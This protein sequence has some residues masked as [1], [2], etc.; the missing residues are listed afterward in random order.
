MIRELIVIARPEVGIRV[1]KVG[2]A[3]A[4]GADVTPLADFLSMEDINIQPL[5]GISEEKLKQEASSFVSATA[6]ELSDLSV[7]Y[8]VQAPD[9]RLDMISEKYHWSTVDE[10]GKDSLWSTFL[11]SLQ[12]LGHISAGLELGEGGVERVPGHNGL[13]GISGWANCYRKNRGQT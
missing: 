13:V 6:V 1:T 8:R 4:V 12:I 9:E 2:V 5:F 7:Y 3:S 11:K 10:I